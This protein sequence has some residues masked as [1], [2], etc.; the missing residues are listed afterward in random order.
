MCLVHH[1]SGLVP[2]ANRM[3][4]GDLVR[5]EALLKGSRNVALSDVVWK[6]FVS[7]KLLS[8]YCVNPAGNIFAHAVIPAVGVGTGLTACH[9]NA[10][11]GIRARH[12]G[13]DILI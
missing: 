4:A 13:R 12:F 9:R 7:V 6:E 8:A 10:P 11:V 1:R 5:L 2:T 3:V